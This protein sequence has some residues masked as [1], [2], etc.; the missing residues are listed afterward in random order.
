MRKTAII[1][2]IIFITTMTSAWTQ[3]TWYVDSSNSSGTYNG[4]LWNT[5]FNTLQEAID[6]A[7]EGDTIFV[8]KGTYNH[9]ATYELKTKNIKLYGSFKGTESSIDERDLTTDTTVLNAQNVCRVFYL[10]GRSSSTVIDGFK[11]TGGRASS[12]ISVERCGGGMYNAN[13]SPMIFNVTISGNTTIGTNGHGGGM[14]NDN[15][16]PVLTNVIISGNTASGGNSYGGGMYNTNSSPILNNVTISGNMANG[17]GGGMFNISTSSPVLT[18]VIISGNRSNLNGGG[19]FNASSPVLTNVIISGNAASANGGGIF[20]SNTTPILTN[21]TICGNFAN[22]GGGIFNSNPSTTPNLYNCIVIG[23]NANTNPGVIDGTPIYAQSMIQGEVSSSGI[24]ADMVFVDYQYAPDNS[25]PT[26]AGDFRLKS[27]SPAINVGNKDYWEGTYTYTQLGGLTLLSYLA[28]NDWS[29]ATDLAGLPRIA[30]TIDLGAYESGLLMV[31]F[32]TNGGSIVPTQYVEKDSTATEPITSR[33]D[34]LFLGWFTDSISGTQW[35]F[36]TMAIIQDTT[37]YARWTCDGLVI[38]DYIWAEF[39][40]DTVGGFPY[41]HNTYPDSATYRT[42]YGLLYD[43]AAAQNACPAGWMLPN[44]TAVAQL[45]ALYN[46]TEL[47]AVGEWLSGTA[48]NSSN[49]GALP[50]GYYHM[51]IDRYELLKGDAFFW[52]E[53]GKVIHLNCH[54]AD[55]TIEEMHWENRVSVRCVKKCE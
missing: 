47:K 46:S 1:F 18:N 9:T 24:T 22:N 50:G 23:N 19:M 14:Y 35:D 17:S 32:I 31:Q 55:I 45:I 53:E 27:G 38:G 25:S 44:S 49:F 33:T 11:I 51:T 37:L 34:Y 5:A 40:A 42:E 10:D 15:S 29:K 2:A 21:V 28:E 48:T 7:S 41:Y 20:V 13:S 36:S 43:Y 26:T 6:A 12:T 54:C 39:N 52:T 4:N 3:S 8:A 30:A 16:S